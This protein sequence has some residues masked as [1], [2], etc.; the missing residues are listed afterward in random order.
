MSRS[1]CRRRCTAIEA[2]RAHL[3]I[4]RNGVLLH[5]SEVELAPGANVYSFVE[6]ADTPGLQEYEAIINSDTDSEPENN[7][8]QAF[9]QVKGAPKVLHAVGE[10]EA[11]RYVSAA[12]RA[13]GLAV[14]EV[15]GQ[16]TPGQHARA[17]GLRPGD[18]EQRLRFRCVACQDGAARALRARC[19][20]WRGEDRRRQELCRRRLLRD[21]AGAPVAGDDA[22]E[23]R[24]QD[25]EP[26]GGL[27][28]GPLRQ[29]GRK[30]R[31]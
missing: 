24:G 26:V 10:P 9:V 20:R 16:C 4:M 12:L 29:H 31:R 23:D 27:R 13:Q 14:D 6:Q 5:E 28:A 22:C 30:N 1:R 11:G 8:Y 17:G 15:R 2:T 18:S 19:G 21:P 7:R 25:S 3:V